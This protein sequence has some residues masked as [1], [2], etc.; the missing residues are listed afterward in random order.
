MA[1]VIGRGRY[2]GETYPTRRA[3]GTPIIQPA[4][5]FDQNATEYTAIEGDPNLQIASASI[6]LVAGSRV[7]IEGLVCFTG[8]V[9]S[10]RG[11]VT[12]PLFSLVNASQSFDVGDFRTCNFL[13]VSDPQP[14]GLVTI[15]LFVTVLG[16][17]G[18]RIDAAG[19]TALTLTEILAT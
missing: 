9:A 17:A 16:N 12:S 5:A 19:L 4:F 13:S 10:G 11:V 7:K 14:A 2:I 6:T 18:A 15:G 1:R 8:S 3:E